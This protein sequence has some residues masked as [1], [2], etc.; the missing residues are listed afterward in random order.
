MNT[1]ILSSP[2][3]FNL[4]VPSMIWSIGWECM[5]LQVTFIIPDYGGM[6]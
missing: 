6:V 3:K 1:V 4:D 2:H 5:L